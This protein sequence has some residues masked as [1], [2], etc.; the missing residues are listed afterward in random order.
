MQLSE[1][2]VACLS[3]HDQGRYVACGTKS[4]HV[5][6][7][8]LSDSLCVVDRNEKQLVASVCR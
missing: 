8:E 7:I 6:L 4:G 2:P 3:F 1:D 5:R